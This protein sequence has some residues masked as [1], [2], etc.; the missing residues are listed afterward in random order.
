MNTAARGTC[1]I[2]VILHVHGRRIISVKSLVAGRSNQV[3]RARSRESR[4][5]KHTRDGRSLS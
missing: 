2:I 1:V 5:Y 3:L 4:E